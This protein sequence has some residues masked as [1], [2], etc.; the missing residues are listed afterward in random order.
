MRSQL[1][2]SLLIVVVLSIG[3]AI[4]FLAEQADQPSDLDLTQSDPD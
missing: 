2:V 1:L 3:A 4:G